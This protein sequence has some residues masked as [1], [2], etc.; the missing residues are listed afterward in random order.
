MA[1]GFTE[2]LCHIL[3]G[4][5]AQLSYTLCAYIIGSFSLLAV[6]PLAPTCPHT[7]I[8]YITLGVLE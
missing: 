3:R 4:E 6:F 5:D 7:N 8:G 2:C 1:L